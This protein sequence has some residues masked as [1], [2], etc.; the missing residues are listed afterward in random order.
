MSERIHPQ[1]AEPEFASGSE[2]KNLRARIKDV[3]KKFGSERLY[4]DGL[5]ATFQ[6]DS[7]RLMTCRYIAKAG[8]YSPGSYVSYWQTLEEYPDGSSMQLH[9]EYQVTGK[10]IAYF[11]ERVVHYDEDEN[12]IS[13]SAERPEGMHALLGNRVLRKLRGII[14]DNSLYSYQVQEITEIL[15]S[16]TEAQLVACEDETVD[17][18]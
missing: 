13:Y 11:S 17:D 15:D 9:R 5:T 12:E 16:L 8:E 7:Q 4:H 1:D 18:L 6:L 14:E 3:A 2:S 10:N